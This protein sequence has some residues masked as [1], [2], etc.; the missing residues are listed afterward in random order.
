MMDDNYMDEWELENIKR[1]GDEDYAV[2][3]IKPVHISE[4]TTAGPLRQNSSNVSNGT[5]SGTSHHCL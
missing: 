3:Y 2:G 5:E 4:I 1:F